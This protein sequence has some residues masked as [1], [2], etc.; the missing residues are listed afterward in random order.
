MNLDK[1]LLEIENHGLDN[2]VKIIPGKEIKILKS[3]AGILRSN[4][5]LTANQGRL[6]EKILTEH[7][8]TLSTA[9]TNLFDSLAAVTWSK[10]FR[11]L[12][13]IRKLYSVKDS[14]GEAFI[15]IEFS[16][17]SQL[18]KTVMDLFKNLPDGYYTPSQKSYT[19]PLTEKNLVA[20]I[21]KLATFNFEIQDSL[22]DQYTTIKSWNFD[23]VQAKFVIEG[24]TENNLMK[25]L[26]QEI[27][28]LESAD[29]DLIQERSRR[30][31]YIVKNQKNPEISLKNLIINRPSINLWIDSTKFSLEDVIVELQNL[32][33]LPL[34]IVLDSNAS[35]TAIEGLKKLEN[36]LKKLEISDDVGIHF[37][38]DNAS[39]KEFNEII[40]K[41]QYNAK[42]TATSKYVIVA[43][44]KLPKFFLKSSWYPMS[45]ISIDTKLRHSKTAVYAQRCDLIIEYTPTKS[46]MENSNPWLS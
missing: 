11:V 22:K 43:Q 36:S 31:N 9:S 29:T 6:L 46:I 2:F 44:Q 40:S 16:H 26:V 41:N 23:E 13:Q 20:I 15:V 8:E 1:V 3:L 19:A 39:G 42:L 14:H 45:V 10:S 7:R 21:E 27:G 18:R 25:G 5:F 34:L 12:E 28:N 24:M 32:K 37:R 30:F 38:L 17:H 35:K 4:V 33:R